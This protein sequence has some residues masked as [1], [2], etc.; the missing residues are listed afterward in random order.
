MV[1]VSQ[2]KGFA[3]HISRQRISTFIETLTLTSKEGKSEALKQEERIN[4]V[5]GSKN[6]TCPKSSVKVPSC[7]G[8]IDEEEGASK[9]NVEVASMPRPKQSQDTKKVSL[10]KMD[11]RPP[12]AR[13]M[14][15]NRQYG[16]VISSEDPTAESVDIKAFLRHFFLL[17][18]NCSANHLKFSES[19]TMAKFSSN[20]LIGCE[21]NKTADWV[22]SAV[23][24]ITPPH[25]CLPFVKFFRLARCS[26]VLP[27]M[28]ADKPL[29]S[30]FELLEM[31]N[32]GLVTDK[33]SVVGRKILD[34]CSDDFE[35][36]AVSSL[37]ENEEIDLYIDA[38]SQTLIFEQCSKLKYCFWRLRFEF[39]CKV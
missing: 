18:E 37:C 23:A 38:E 34:P 35:Q 22:T 3:S 26:F 17:F 11:V 12:Y 9:N 10:D 15:E 2:I 29:R 39:N 36:R 32:S 6:L 30:I 27:L 28:V 19:T 8:D 1:T 16:L 21:D 20:L 5:L 7:G 24:D 14:P 33:W 4:K 13:T 31:Q 25:S